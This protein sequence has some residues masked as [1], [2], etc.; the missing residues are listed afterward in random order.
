MNP[1][2]II[3][4]VV[5]SIILLGLVVVLFNF[6]G[7]WFQALLSNAKVGLPDLI[8]MRFRK[9]D[10]RTVV[11]SRIRGHRADRGDARQDRSGVGHGLLDRPCRA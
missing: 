1:L 4:I 6:F 7:L 5:A 2:Y 9:V 3:L 8:G 11:L 10:A